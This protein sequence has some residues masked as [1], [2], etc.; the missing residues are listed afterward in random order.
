MNQVVFV[1][2]VL[3]CL[4]WT[5]VAQY[6]YP[7]TPAPSGTTLFST[8]GLSFRVY[9]AD[10]LVTSLSVSR[11]TIGRDVVAA[12]LLDTTC[13][14]SGADE[15]IYSSSTLI[16]DGAYKTNYLA[17]TNPVDRVYST[18]SYLSW[19]V[20]PRNSSDGQNTTYSTGIRYFILPP[21]GTNPPPC[22]NSLNMTC[23]GLPGIQEGFSFS[24]DFRPTTYIFCSASRYRISCFTP[25]CPVPPVDCVVAP[26]YSPWS[27]CTIDQNACTKVRV[28]DVLVESAGSGVECPSL[29]ERTQTTA[30]TIEECQR[31][32]CEYSTV[33]VEGNCSTAC[34]PGTVNTTVFNV[35]LTPLSL[36]TQNF[37]AVVSVA[38]APC[39]SNLPCSL[40]EPTKPVNITCYT[41][42]YQGYRSGG[43]EKIVIDLG[44][45][46][47]FNGTIISLI[48]SF[49]ISQKSSG[50][51]V[52]LDSQN[53]RV[54]GSR[55]ELGLLIDPQDAEARTGYEFD[56]LYTPPGNVNTSLYA[57]NVRIVPFQ[58]VAQ[59]RVG[60]VIMFA[61]VVPSTPNL[62]LMVKW[63][64][65]VV[66]CAPY[67]S[68]SSAWFTWEGISQL[69]E[70]DGV[71]NLA[72]TSSLQ[73]YVYVGTFA[74]SDASVAYGTPEVICD[75][76]GNP[77]VDYLAPVPIEDYTTLTSVLPDDTEGTIKA[78]VSN[79]TGEIGSVGLVS[80]FPIDIAA[81]EDR[82]GEFTLAAYYN[83]GGTG[84]DVQILSSGTGVRVQDNSPDTTTTTQFLVDFEPL[85]SPGGNFTLVNFTLNY[86]TNFGGFN[87]PDTFPLISFALEYSQT[88]LPS[89]KLLGASAEPGS[90]FLRIRFSSLKPS[91]VAFKL[92][93]ISYEG[94][95][96]IAFFYEQREKTIVLAMA[97]PFD[98]SMFGFDRVLFLDTDATQQVYWSG[99]FVDNALGPRP[100][101]ISAELLR[102]TSS[103]IWNR[104][105][106]TFSSSIGSFGVASILAD[107]LRFNWTNP[108]VTKIEVTDYS[109]SGSSITYSVNPVCADINCFAIDG[110]LFV[111]V[112][113]MVSTEGVL[114]E[115]YEGVRVT[116]LTPLKLAS[117]VKLDSKTYLISLNKQVASS[118]SSLTASLF[119]APSA[120]SLEPDNTMICVFE[121]DV[122]TGGGTPVL[123]PLGSTVSDKVF[124]QATLDQPLAIDCLKEADTCALMDL[125]VAWMIVLVYLQAAG[126]L[127]V[128]FGAW[129]WYALS[130][131]KS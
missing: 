114:M 96:Q 101:V 64:E 33:T 129:K 6:G 27:A 3:V 59:D 28:K 120:C 90:R 52:S 21:T 8:C 108:I 12:Y 74:I 49:S 112:R 57:S 80:R 121:T 98:Y 66:P 95:N 102:T 22:I 11:S 91:Q 37:T 61:S 63:S 117:A 44:R 70:G 76:A 83:D 124:N 94:T 92:A 2:V 103:P 118:S 87:L 110:Q 39:R 19:W 15:G 69:G 67:E 43:I 35:S 53:V 51:P 25:L 14:F 72:G 45:S 123:Q 1:S 9:K 79:E 65:A 71:S 128:L 41:Q 75:L 38:Y 17:T 13:G 85:F 32:R 31:I 7:W 97:F 55:V 34:G 46:L 5:S 24:I 81:I 29:V 56:V 89:P 50:T 130:A 116:D 78:Y 119:P 122:C 20:D 36:C 54:N 99:V 86:P 42:G 126:G 58:C 84:E 111:T 16:T 30:C 60:P 68:I 62:Y 82:V 107:S 77:N 105:R 93:D 115:E 125:P 73:T 109:I 104:L 10:G 131:A 106:I 18:C 26:D 48:A 47:T 4:C 100:S 88:N 40:S 23:G 127:T 113:G